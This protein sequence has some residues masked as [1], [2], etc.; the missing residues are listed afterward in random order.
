MNRSSSYIISFVV[1]IVLQLLI[2]NNIQFSG[3]VNP[4]V[5]VMFILILPMAIPTWI[6]LLLSFMTG[7]VIDI[8]AGTMGVHAF[9]TVMAG[10][11]RPWVLSLNIT[12]EA[13]EP[14]TSPSSHNSGL[15]WFFIYTVTVVFIHHFTLFFVEVFSFTNFFHTI[16]RVLLSTLVTTFFI[17]LFDIIRPRR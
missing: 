10:F 4:Y 6:L 15:R 8:F 2:F 7:I 11:V 1:L 14:E 17:I 3:F 16:L 9:A 13:S 12:S 5:Y